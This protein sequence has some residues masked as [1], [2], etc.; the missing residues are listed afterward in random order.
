VWEMYAQEKKTPSGKF[1][2]KV[3]QGALTF[4]PLDGGKGSKPYTCAS[5]PSTQDIVLGEGVFRNNP[6]FAG[7]FN[8]HVAADPAD[9]KNPAKFY[10]AEPCNWYARYLHEHSFGHKAYGFSYDDA[11]EQAPFFSAKGSEVVVTLYWDT[12]PK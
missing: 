8:R 2:G 1:L 11:S 9:W 10:Q 7:A 6:A 3:V 4:T 5:K 12:P